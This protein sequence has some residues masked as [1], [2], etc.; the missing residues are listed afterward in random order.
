MGYSPRRVMYIAESLYLKG[1]ISYHRTDNTTYPKTL[2]LKALV[3]MFNDTK[4]FGEYARMLSK[5]KQLKPTAGKKETKDHP[6]IHPPVKRRP[7]ITRQYIR[8]LQYPKRSLRRTNG[9][10]TNSW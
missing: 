5:K 4:E 3:T 10:Y 7:R 8:Y 9:R 2:D 6:P 1:F